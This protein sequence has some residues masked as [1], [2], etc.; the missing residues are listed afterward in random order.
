MALENL[1]PKQ[2]T[3]FDQIER[4]VRFI[5][6]LGLIIGIPALLVVGINLQNA[7]VEALEAKISLL[8]QQNVVAAA[9]EVEAYRKLLDMQSKRLNDEIDSLISAGLIADST[10]VSLRSALQRPIELGIKFEV[11]LG[12]STY[13]F[14]YFDDL[15]ITRRTDSLADATSEELL[16]AWLRE[17]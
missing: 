12:E 7:R 9:T 10:I 2:P 1:V 17:E 4:W 6:N 5:K 15:T 14:T 11:P 13:T 16:K 3:R 8:E